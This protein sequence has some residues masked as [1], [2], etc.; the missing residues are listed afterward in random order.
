MDL[1]LRITLIVVSLVLIVLVMLQAKGSG[2]GSIFGGDGGIYR[3]RRGLEGTIFNATIV[4]S[5]VFIVVSLLLVFFDPN[6]VP[7]NPVGP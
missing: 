7:A 1:Y 5:T 4:F 6:V 2:L 3:T